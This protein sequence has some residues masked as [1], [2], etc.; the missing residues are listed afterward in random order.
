MPERLQNITV[1]DTKETVAEFLRSLKD[2]E[3]GTDIV[4]TGVTDDDGGHFV[5]VMTGGRNFVTNVH[6][7]RWLAD[8]LERH[9]GGAGPLSPSPG[10]VQN[11]ANLAMTLREAADRVEEANKK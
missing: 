5:A 10:M 9:L 8:F 4:I 1:I 7:A 2:L 11:M 6:N 3:H